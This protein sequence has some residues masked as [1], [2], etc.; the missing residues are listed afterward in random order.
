MTKK[1][2]NNLRGELQPEIFQRIDAFCPLPYK[3]K[4]HI[5]APIKRF[6]A[7]KRQKILYCKFVKWSVCSPFSALRTFVMSHTNWSWAWLTS[8]VSFLPWSSS[9]SLKIRDL[10]PLTRRDLIFVVSCEVLYLRN[11][12]F[13]KWDQILLLF[14]SFWDFCCFV[15]IHLLF[16]RNFSWWDFFLND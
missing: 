1:I 9:W 2:W 4:S 8:Q 14:V 5:C 3:V 13:W 15:L 10:I 7:W 6:I 16:L 11:I 12:I